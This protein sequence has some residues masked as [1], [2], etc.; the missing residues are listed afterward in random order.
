MTAAIAGV[1]G[2]LTPDMR[3]VRIVAM[4]IPI[5]GC[6]GP[7]HPSK[8]RTDEHSRSRMPIRPKGIGRVP[9]PLGL[10]HHDGAAA[11]GIVAGAGMFRFVNEAIMSGGYWDTVDPVWDKISIDGVEEFLET[12]AQAP[13]HAA[14][15]FAAHFCQSEVCNGGL[16]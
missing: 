5:T 2:T 8:R 4:G 6:F 10:R 1:S 15:L 11:R 14:L 16:H 7:S 12:Y 3:R 13:L 9:L